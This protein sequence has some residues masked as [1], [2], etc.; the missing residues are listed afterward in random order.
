MQQ[1]TTILS[2]IDESYLRRLV[3]PFADGQFEVILFD[4]SGTRLPMSGPRDGR[5]AQS[6]AHHGSDSA[7]YVYDAGKTLSQL[8]DASIQPIRIDEKIIGHVAV[9]GTNAPPDI[10]STAD[11]ISRVTDN[12]DTM[13]I[14]IAD[15]L[16]TICVMNATHWSRLAQKRD[17]LE[18]AN[19]ALETRNSALAA[20]VNRLKEL[21]PSQSQFLATVSHELKTPLTSI[22][23]YSEMLA[24]GFAGALNAEQLD[25]VSIVQERG[26]SLLTMIDN[27]LKIATI[28]RGGASL[29]LAP[30]DLVSIIEDVMRTLQPSAMKT[31]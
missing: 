5:H 9:A 21:D 4:A 7:D 19:R 10:Q 20:T 8:E 14:T 29:D 24:E 13:A 25:Y 3:K 22:L 17:Q 16:A 26:Q 12:A 31:K 6:A 18:T 15:T 30:V 23:G 11:E 28:Q 27:L 2:Y 1:P